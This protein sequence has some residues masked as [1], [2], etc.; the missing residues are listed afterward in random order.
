MNNE[1][2]ERS[3]DTISP[4][5]KRRTK[6][7]FVAFF[8]IGGACAIYFSAIS[9]TAN[10]N[11]QLALSN[12]EP[13]ADIA[14]EIFEGG[15][16]I[17]KGNKQ[18]DPSGKLSLDSDPD[19]D[20]T[21]TYKMTIRNPGPAKGTG[22]DPLNILLKL[23]PKNRAVDYHA[24]GLREFSEVLISDGQSD[25]NSR[26]D[27]AG[28]LSGTSVL[29]NLD[30]KNRNL[31]KIAFQSHNLENDAASPDGQI[32]EVFFGDANGSNLAAVQSR[33]SRAM[34]YM[35]EQ[36]SAVM[37]QQAFIIGTF[38]DAKMQLETQRKMQELMARAHKDYHPSEQICRF[39]TFVK[40]LAHTE[41]A[42]ELDM[43]ALNRALMGE[44]LAIEHDS[45]AQGPRMEVPNRI[46]QFRTK[47]CNPRDNNDSLDLLCNTLVAATPAQR[48]RFNKDI[49]YFRTLES[50]LT[51][52]ANF[53]DNA[54]TNDEE[55][56][57]ALAQNLYFPTVFDEVL[58]EDL[59]ENVVSHYN[60]R[61]FMA[62]IGV[63]HNS[64]VNIV[65]MK[66][67]APPGQ[68]TVAPGA[69]P[70]N[71]IAPPP[72]ATPLTENT[73]WTFMKAFIRELGLPA[74]TAA[75]IHAYLGER[76]SYYAQM[77]VL[78]KKIFQS[79]HF[80][81]NLYDKPANVDRIGAAIDA[82]ALMSLR[83]RFDSS[84]RRE[85]LTSML[86]EDELQDHVEN[87]SIRIFSNVQEEQTT[88]S[89]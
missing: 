47:Y 55:D 39:G 45:A 70:P 88:L 12:F 82:I 38:F 19:S 7:V 27:W 58:D 36:L 66:T 61:S 57:F 53:A 11:T 1:E 75:E 85:M 71:I 6:A 78:T 24:S 81:T 83:D 62:K 2:K 40:S 60:T 13:G 56:L 3:V 52:N 31:L 43:R 64:F 89:P 35:T 29:D 10:K 50:K 44:V 76:P 23:N 41:R 9:T 8:A 69:W 4:S 15:Q 86:V 51:V 65:G 21:L 68:A 42:Y 17:E 80:Y 46:T 34:K 74:M 26:T 20:T 49:D 18:I 22:Q 63:A 79:P 37:M 73:G 54:L 72:P 5:Q 25:V 87:I 67:S 77:E 14:Y 32:V 84:L 28:A 33:W 48:D 59:A 16:I 30:Q